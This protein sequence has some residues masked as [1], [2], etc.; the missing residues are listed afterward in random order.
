MAAQIYIVEDNEIMRAML[1]EF[2]NEATDMAVSGAVASAEEALMGVHGVRSDLIL[3]DMALPGMNGIELVTQ[4]LE[5]S[6]QLLCLM[7][8]GHRETAYV[9]QAM[10]AGARGY[11]LKEQPEEL[12]GAIR[13][14]LDGE[15]YVS[16]AL[17][18]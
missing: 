1:V 6:P 7:Y 4:L 11:V 8:S 10:A 17:K 15:L 9:R 14:V 3:I 16:R 12:P 5:E 18:T 13:K 2:V